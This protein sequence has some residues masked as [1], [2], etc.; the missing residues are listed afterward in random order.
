MT[1]LDKAREW[2]EAVGGHEDLM[3]KPRA[4]VEVIQSLPNQWIDAEK[5]RGVV[6]KYEGN[7]YI[8]E[9]VQ[10][11]ADLLP[12]PKLPTLA[13]MT[14]EERA[15]CQWMQAQVFPTA[16][17]L[18]I[19][20]CIDEYE[21]SAIILFTD[22]MAKNVRWEDIAP[23]TGEPKLEWPGSEVVEPPALPEGMRLADHEEYGRVVVSPKDDL[24]G[25]Y[26]VFCPQDNT[27]YGA[28]WW[29]T[30]KS[31]LTFLGGDQHA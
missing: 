25:D 16:S 5:L 28:N 23:L 3:S 24:D 7:T 11:F 18:G 6:S 27:E 17:T 12:V 13:D 8:S 29:Y 20:T 14:A 22:G 19:I 31:E 9:I 2:A 1:D 4:A 15:A 10:D 21:R 26:R 30:H